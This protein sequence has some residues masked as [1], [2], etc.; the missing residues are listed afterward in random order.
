V[1]AS[2][3]SLVF[4]AKSFTARCSTVKRFLHAHLFAYEMG[5][6]ESLRR[7]EEVKEET[8]DYMRLIRPFLIGNHRDPHFILNMD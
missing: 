6:Q 3:L 2:T 8:K 4:N 7:P 1:K 5:M